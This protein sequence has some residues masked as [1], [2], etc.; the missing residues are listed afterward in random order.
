VYGHPRYHQDR[1]ARASVSRAID[2]RGESF[3]TGS[4]LHSV[5]GDTGA[6]TEL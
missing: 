3:V 4:K 5:F 1:A 6:R 2:E